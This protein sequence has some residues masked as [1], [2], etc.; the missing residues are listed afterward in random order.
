M[1]GFLGNAKKW[2]NRGLAP[3]NMRLESLT[4]ERVEV[5]RLSRLAATGHFDR[6]VFP[7]LRQF[8][9][10]DPSAIIS[11]AKRFEHQLARFAAESAADCYSF[12]ND[13][14]QSPDAEVLY[15]MVRGI[16]P[17]QVV[18]IGSG[19]STLLI[20][21]AIRDG[22]LDTN[23]TSIDP[24]PRREIAS[25]SDNVLRCRLEDIVDETVFGKLRPNDIL[26]IDSSHQIKAG[27]D[28]VRLFLS[29][30]PSLTPGVIIHV[31]D[32]FLPY[33]YPKQWIVVNRWDWTEQYLLQALLEGSDVYE[34]L[35]CGHYLQ[36]RNPEMRNAFRYWTGADA[37]SVWFRKRPANE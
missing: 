13:Y 36:R 11:A 20:R 9:E 25:H 8:E 4:A 7:V 32:V 15:T 28:V 26:F 29:V 33:D 14:Y 22:G 19:N 1:M 23:L 3:L 24:N 12:N 34:V 31:H 17:R 16:E 27:N 18:E 10:C 2:V 6:P 30:I 35:W 37:C 21:H 5:D